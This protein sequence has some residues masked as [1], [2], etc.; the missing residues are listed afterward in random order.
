VAAPE[1]A[2]GRIPLEQVAPAH[3]ASCIR[4]AAASN[5]RIPGQRAA[6]ARV[7]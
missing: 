2:H 6:E 4:V 7:T 3:D 1:C 5:A